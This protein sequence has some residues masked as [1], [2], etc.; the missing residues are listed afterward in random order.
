MT[1]ATCPKDG[2]ALVREE[3]HRDHALTRTRQVFSCGH[4][5]WTAPEGLWVPRA[6]GAQR[7]CTG[8]G[9]D[10]TPTAAARHKCARCRVC[11]CGQGR[12]GRTHTLAACPKRRVPA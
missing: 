8:C 10:F 6:S 9:E 3:P 11:P 1:L 5:R 7:P 12:H 2:A 4:D